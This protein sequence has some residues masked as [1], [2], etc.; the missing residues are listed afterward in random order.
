MPQ[1][2]VSIS[3]GLAPGT[4]RSTSR[5]GATAANAFW[6]QWPCTSIGDST[7]VK[8]TSKRPAFASR[9]MNSSNSSACLETAIALSP[10]P[11]A[12]ASSR[13][14]SRHDGSRPTMAM[15]ACGE[16]QQRVDQGA[17]AIARLVD[18]AAGQEGAAAAVVA[19]V[20]LSSVCSV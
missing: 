1:H 19:A 10:R 14:V 9:A 15:P 6:W 7:G 2:E 4:R 11:S 5:I 12:S 3:A 8:A 13:S 17:D 16:R 20:A 18:A